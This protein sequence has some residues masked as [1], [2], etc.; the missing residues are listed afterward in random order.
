M[1]IDGLIDALQDIFSQSDIA[2]SQ[3]DEV[4]DIVGILQD[5]GIDLSLYTP[6]EITQAL[7]FALDNTDSD[8][9]V[10]ESKDVAFTGSSKDSLMSELRQAH[11]NA[12]YYENQ[13]KNDNISSTYRSTC[14]FKLEQALKKITELTEQ[15]NRLK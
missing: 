15:I 2:V 4:G 14:T 10:A 11:H 5:C 12:E 3:V 1:E 9:E 8:I 6:D 13:L 7:E